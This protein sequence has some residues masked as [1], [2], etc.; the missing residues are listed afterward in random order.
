MSFLVNLDRRRRAS[1][2]PTSWYPMVLGYQEIYKEE[3]N[4]GSRAATVVPGCSP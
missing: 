4:S 2:V 3:R 1:H